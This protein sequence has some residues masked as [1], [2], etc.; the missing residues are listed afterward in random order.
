MCKAARQLAPFRSETAGADD[1][2]SSIWS[3]RGGFATDSSPVAPP[4]EV[5]NVKN[6]DIRSRKARRCHIDSSRPTSR[7]FVALEHHKVLRSS[8]PPER[9]PQTAPDEHP[10][11]S[12]LSRQSL[13][14]R[15]SGSVR[16]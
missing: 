13:A 8:E 5:P 9:L 11:A 3:A 16:S 2:P 10:P 14:T 15:G 6:G 7:A 1:S 12:I 4:S